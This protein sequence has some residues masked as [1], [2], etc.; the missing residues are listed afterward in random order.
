MVSEEYK[1]GHPE[2]HQ[3]VASTYWKGKAQICGTSQVLH[4][5]NV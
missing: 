4:Q 2:L 1:Y 3:L 5:V